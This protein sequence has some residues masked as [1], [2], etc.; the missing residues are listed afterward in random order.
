MDYNFKFYFIFFEL[1]DWLFQIK[2]LQHEILWRA[3]L[4]KGKNVDVQ[5]CYALSFIFCSAYLGS[6]LLNIHG[7]HV[8]VS[9]HLLILQINVANAIPIKP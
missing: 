3:A 5:V 9:S 1:D 8:A 7:N 4:I 6:V 2:T